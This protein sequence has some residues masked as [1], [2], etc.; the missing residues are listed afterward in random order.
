MIRRVLF[1]LVSAVA[2]V[3]SVSAADM[4]PADGPGGLKDA[5]YIPVQSW[6]GFYIGVNGGYGWSASDSRL[7][8][9]AAELDY[10]YK[11]YCY[12]D[13]DAGHRDLSPTGGFGGGQIGYNAQRNRF[14]FGIEADI[15][16]SGIGDS[17]AI[18][19]LGG[20]AAV[21]GKTELNWFGTVRGRVGYT[22]DRALVYFTGGFAF[23]GVKDTLGVTS[24]WGDTAKVSK[25]DTK[26]GFVLGGGI[27]YALN[28][29]WS[30]KGEYQ[31]I[32]LGSEKLSADA[33]DYCAW[34][35]GT[36]HADHTYH[37]VR[38]GLNYRIHDEYVPLK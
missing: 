9:S 32:D 11:Y 31:Y 17:A 23:G 4:Y 24:P 1:G 37:T 6:T 36:L 34:A 16:G 30:L 19:L 10:C 2:F 8:G 5:P 7:D 26:T 14:V 15:Q 20:D 3:T 38:A 18:D 35:S 22:F 28:S 33:G 21:R 27:E 25:D 29:S 13:K 12:F